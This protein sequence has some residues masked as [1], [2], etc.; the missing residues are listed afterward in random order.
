MWSRP[1]TPG[2]ISLVVRPAP[3]ADPAAVLASDT[4]FIGDVGRPDLLVAGQA[5]PA[6][7][8]TAPPESIARLARRLPGATLVLP[9]HEPGRPAARRCRPR[10]CRRLASSASNFTLAP[11][12]RERFVE[13]ITDG[14]PAAYTG[15]FGYDAVL[16]RKARP[17]MDEQPS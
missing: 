10:R 11:M 15:Y 13:I 2:S 4:L 14:Q 7:R 9:A 6:S 5:C 17:L 8:C 12:T 1:A 16:N 3:G